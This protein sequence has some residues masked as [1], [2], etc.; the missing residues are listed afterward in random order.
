MIQ[1]RDTFQI[2]FGRIDDAVELFTR[3][4]KEVAAAE[5]PFPYEILTDLSGKMYALVTCIQL[6]SIAVWE[7]TAPAIWAR[8]EFE[9]WYKSFNQSVED[10]RRE[11]FTVEQ[12][13]EGWSVAGA[14]V[15][16]SCFRALE[17][18]VRDTV[19]LIKTYGAMLVDCGVGERPRI[20]TDA[21]GKMFNVVIEIEAPNLQTWDEHRRGMFRRPEFQVW[22]QRLLTC[23]SH[24]SH[25]FYTFAA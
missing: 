21:S 17:W 11:F 14:V 16:R 4:R 20:L 22:F 23:V 25:E 3:F 13:N 7:Q 12:A 6:P 9:R 24:G 5:L 15:V 2:K 19:D 18:R 10:G 1:V 8:P